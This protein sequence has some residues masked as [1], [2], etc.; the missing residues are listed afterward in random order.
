MRVCMLQFIKNKN[1]KYGEIKSARKLGVRIKSIGD[2]FTRTSKDIDETI[3]RAQ[4]M[5]ACLSSIDWRITSR[6]REPNS[7]NLSN[8]Y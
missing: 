3:A 2:G 7:E 5:V 1:A 4:L 8:V 6:T